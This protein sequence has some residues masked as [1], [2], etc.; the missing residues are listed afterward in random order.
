M[1]VVLLFSQACVKTEYVK[2][3]P[4]LLFTVVSGNMIFVEGATVSLYETQ[5]DWESGINVV[6]S[7][8]T[9]STGQALFEDLKEQR[10][11]FSVVKGELNNLA[12]IQAT[13]DSLRVGQRSEVLV[14]I[15]KSDL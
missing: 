14:K 7:L 5:N 15:M 1:T 8:Q 10:Y 6:D 11:F 3:E 9:D 2:P 13:W 4:Q 12:D